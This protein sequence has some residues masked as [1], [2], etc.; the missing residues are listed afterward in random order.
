MN[1][2]LPIWKDHS[3]RRGLLTYWSTKD[4][5]PE[6]PQSIIQLCKKASLKRCVGISTN[7]HTFLEAWKGLKQEGIQFCF[8]LQ[9]TLCDDVADHSEA[10]LKSEHKVLVFMRNSAAYEDLIRLYTACHANQINRYY[11]QRFDCKSL[12]QHWTANLELVIPFFDSFI[13][14]N[15]LK[16]GA[17]IVPAF[18]VKPTLF[19]ETNS[20]VPFAPLI[21]AALD[22]FNVTKDH[23]EVKVKTICYEKYDDFE[24]YITERAR[25]KRATF[26]KPN[27]D[28]MC[29][30][31]FCFE[32]WETIR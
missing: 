17:S 28:H 21:D 20:G 6:G 18:P 9:L 12:A 25:H 10:S 19:R 1:D 3:S 13:H 11:I 15:T 16:Y 32:D 14:A 4:V 26:N 8:G 27:L 5:T 29:S 30:P 31:R 2:I 7:F 23:E 22:R 24:P